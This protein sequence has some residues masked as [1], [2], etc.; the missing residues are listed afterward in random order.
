ML[1]M[2]NF[3]IIK[4]ILFSLP[5]VPRFPKSG[6]FSTFQNY[7]LA[8]FIWVSGWV[9]SSNPEGLMFEIGVRLQCSGGTV[10][11]LHL[12]V[13]STWMDGSITVGSTWMD[14]SIKI[15]RLGATVAQY[16]RCTIVFSLRLWCADFKSTSVQQNSWK[17]A[18]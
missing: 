13:G 1:L 5:K 8:L 9:L 3:A 16:H 6:P 18:A 7:W 10:L 11:P 4:K 2:F 17:L 15:Q 12:T 14:G